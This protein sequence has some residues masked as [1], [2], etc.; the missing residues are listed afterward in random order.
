MHAERKKK[1][2]PII[3]NITIKIQ[4]EIHVIH[5]FYLREKPIEN[6]SSDSQRKSEHYEE[7]MNR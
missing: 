2:G 7:L 4:N 5:E 3:Q 1:K 6:L